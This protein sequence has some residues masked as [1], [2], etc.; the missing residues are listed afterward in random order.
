[1]VAELTTFVGLDVSERRIEAHVRP[2]ALRRGFATGPEGLAALLAWLTE[3]AAP[4]IVLEAT[5]GLEKP[6]ARCLAEAGLA[7]AVVNPRH[8]RQFAKGLALLAKTDRLDAAVIARYGEL[9]RPVP[10]PPASEP[11]GR[12]QALVLR[13][14][15]LA[16]QANAE[17]NRLRRAQDPAV[18]HSLEEH[19]RWLKAELARLDELVAAAIAAEPAWRAKAAI[20]ASVPGV[21]PCTCASLLGLLPE[22]G[23]RDAKRIASLTGLA[24]VAHDSGSLRGKRSVQGGRAAVRR[25]LY[26]A[27]L[28]ATRHNPLLRTYYR[29]L[30]AAGKAKKLALVASMRK[31]LV[32]LNAMVR[33]GTVWDQ[34][35]MPAPL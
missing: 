7:V 14:Q 8:V 31:L 16:R 28:V 25:V 1:M 32:I 22:L 10:R 3:L 13:R 9:A 35:R 15:H 24:P 12:L 23:A 2:Q 26:M 29:R 34:D 6:L 11:E 33:D 19:L 27:A 18:R 4:L 30:V 20:L 17:G 5:G 21:G